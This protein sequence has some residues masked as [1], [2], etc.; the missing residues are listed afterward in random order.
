MDKYILVTSTGDHGDEIDLEGFGIMKPEQWEKI[1]NN[2]PNESFELYYGSNGLMCF[3]GRKD[4]LSHFKTQLLSENESKALCKLLGAVWFSE[5]D[6]E[7]VR[8]S[9][10]LFLYDSDWLEENPE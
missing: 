3:D 6:P 2:V 4:Y 10:G 7:N 5:Y 1:V 8:A 9:Y